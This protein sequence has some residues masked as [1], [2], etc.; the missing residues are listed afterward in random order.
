MINYYAGDIKRMSDEELKSLSKE[1][2]DAGLLSQEDPCDEPEDWTYQAR[3][4]YHEI[5]RELNRRKDE[6][7]KVTDPAAYEKMMVHRK[8]QADLIRSCTDW[9][10][11][12]ALERLNKNFVFGEFIRFKI[13]R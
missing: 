11:K 2:L 4:R 3:E 9:Y 1:L 8:Q 13:K 7:L 5:W 10:S 12:N 6:S